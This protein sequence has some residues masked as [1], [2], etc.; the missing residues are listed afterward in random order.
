[1]LTEKKIYVVESDKY[2][3]SPRIT[4]ERFRVIVN[5]TNVVWVGEDDRYILNASVPNM[6]LNVIRT[7]EVAYVVN[8]ESYKDM[9]LEGM[10]IRTR[11]G[12]LTEEDLK[13]LKIESVK[14]YTFGEMYYWMLDDMIYRHITNDRDQ[15]IFSY[16]D[17]E[18]YNRGILNIVALEEAKKQKII[19]PL[20]EN[21]VVT[22]I[23]D[24]NEER[25]TK[26]FQTKC[27]ERCVVHVTLQATSKKV[28][29][30]M[31]EIRDADKVP[32]INKKNYQKD[33][34]RFIYDDYVD[35]VL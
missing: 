16:R 25:E 22:I 29:Q 4:G 35:Y 27:V 9:N 31:Q 15:G 30:Q 24:F 33:Y 18:E 23:I 32:N 28:Q 3:F 26:I 2:V 1:M 21:E 19:L 11:M 6:K 17:L 13:K 14:Y 8:V 10:S 34:K 12:L 7:S 20:L 5:Q